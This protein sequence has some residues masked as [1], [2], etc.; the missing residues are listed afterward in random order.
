MPLEPVV[1]VVTLGM[2]EAPA[3][4]AA[5]VTVTPGSTLPKASETRT[6]SGFAKACPTIVDCPEPETIAIDA[7]VPAMFVRVKLAVAATPNTE[8]VTL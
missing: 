8:A 1:A 6:I 3:A 5:N 2:V 7:G 4:G